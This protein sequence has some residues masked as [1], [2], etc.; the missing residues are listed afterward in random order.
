MSKGSWTRVK[1]RVGYDR[2]K[3]RIY[4]SNR[5]LRLMM[6]ERVIRMRVPIE[7]DIYR[8]YEDL[9]QLHGALRS[10]ANDSKELRHWLF[11]LH[12]QLDTME[13]TK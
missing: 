10:D 5:D 12:K 2:N 3:E 13:A 7:S 6:D 9:C 4:K 1:D 11:T 8:E